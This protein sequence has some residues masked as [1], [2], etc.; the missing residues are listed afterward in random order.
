M[1]SLIATI[2]LVAVALCSACGTESTT[3]ASTDKPAKPASTHANAA[4]KKK[5][6]KP[7]PKT[8]TGR[9]KAAL[10]ATDGGPYYGGNL[11]VESATEIKDSTARSMEIELKSP[12]GGFNGVSNTDLAD[13]AAAAFKA[14]YGDAGY[15][16]RTFIFFV[17]GLVDSE[18]GEPTDTPL[19]SFGMTYAQAKRID[20]S[21]E[22]RLANIDWTNYQNSRHPAVERD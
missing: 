4:A 18:T 21:S 1:R 3:T 2:A 20:W 13:A 10:R 9:V 5:A 7:K 8:M 17:G 15:K 6:P 12:E 11:K 14:I 16:H 22:D 19:G